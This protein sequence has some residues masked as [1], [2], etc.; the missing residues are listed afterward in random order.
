[1]V[2]PYTM[3]SPAKAESQKP[4]Q[5]L[6]GPKI[7]DNIS[8]WML[9][10][11]ISLKKISNVPRVKKRNPNRL[12][13]HQNSGGALACSRPPFYCCCYI[14]TGSSHLKMETLETSN[15]VG[16]QSTKPTFPTNG[17]SNWLFGARMW[18]LISAEG[19]LR[20]NMTYDNHPIHPF[21]PFN[22]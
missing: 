2:K 19:A 4:I 8:S 5:D 20:T 7:Q 17:K 11:N 21:V 18:A 14:G 1:M 22:T 13:R 10:D 6:A 15:T 3:N 9:K 16:I 12:F